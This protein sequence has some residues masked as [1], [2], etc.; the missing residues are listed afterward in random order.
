MNVNKFQNAHCFTSRVDY[1]WTFPLT[2]DADGKLR[3]TWDLGVEHGSKNN[4]AWCEAQNNHRPWWSCNY[5]CEPD[6]RLENMPQVSEI[7]ALADWS[8]R[9]REKEQRLHRTSIQNRKY[10]TILRQWLQTATGVQDAVVQI[11][12]KNGFLIWDPK[13]GMCLLRKKPQEVMGHNPF[14]WQDPNQSWSW[15]WWIRYVKAK[16]D[17]NYTINRHHQ[18][19]SVMF[20]VGITY[21]CRIQESDIETTSL[22]LL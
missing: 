21:D 12:L 2:S 14:V 11:L 15:Q 17:H 5:A 22:D 6:R 9:I 20:W 3:S 10:L 1:A 8:G 4:I 19:N 16:K 13:E 18:R 7:G